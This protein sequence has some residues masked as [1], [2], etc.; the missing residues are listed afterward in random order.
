MACS[1]FPG[2]LEPQVED[3]AEGAWAKE[4]LML[5]MGFLSSMGKSVPSDCW[6]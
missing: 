6:A 2:L 3:K 1:L 4:G 5:A